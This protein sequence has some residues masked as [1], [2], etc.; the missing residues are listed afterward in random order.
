MAGL[1]EREMEY[2]LYSKTG[3]FD[4]HYEQTAGI[5]EFK[6]SFIRLRIKEEHCSWKVKLVRLR[7]CLEAKGNFRI[8]YYLSEDGKV[9]HTTYA[10]GKCVKFPYMEEGSIRLGPCKTEEAFRGR[11]IYPK[12]L[13]HILKSKEFDGTTITMVVKEDNFSSIRG[14]E[15]AG[16]VPCGKVRK[17]K[18]TKKFYLVDDETKAV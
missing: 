14:V 6:P 12:I 8:F 11:G 1:E 2:I 7:F 9:V 16:F 15:K 10:I 17:C 3:S 5:R 18:K 13:T 4:A